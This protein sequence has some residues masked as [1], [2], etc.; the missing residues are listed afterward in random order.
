MRTLAE[1]VY[2][3]SEYGVPQELPHA[4]STLEHPLVFDVTARELKEMAHRGLVEILSERRIGG[5]ESSL[6]DRLSFR[7]LR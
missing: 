1:A 7:R 6:I 2:L 4:G 5:D 3:D